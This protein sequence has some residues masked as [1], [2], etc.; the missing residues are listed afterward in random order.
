MRLKN[1]KP[2]LVNLTED[3]EGK[4]NLA[5]THP[6][7]LAAMTAKI[8]S[9]PF[10]DPRGRSVEREDHDASEIEELKALGYIE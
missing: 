1:Q 6:A 8:S 2:R 7:E 4:T 5:K 9:L 10:E 3:P